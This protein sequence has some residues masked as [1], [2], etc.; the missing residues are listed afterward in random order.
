MEESSESRKEKLGTMIIQA[1]LASKDQIEE[2][3]Q[4]QK[5]FGGSLGTNLVEL[6]LL[7]D[8]ALAVFLSK[9]VGIARVEAAEW[10]VI[11]QDTLSKIPVRAA[12]QLSIIP[13]SE[14]EDA[15]VV[16]MAD[17]SDARIVERIEQNIGY[18]LSPK[19]APEFRIHI[20]LKQFYDVPLPP[21]LSRLLHHQSTNQKEDR[22]VFHNLL[23]KVA[24][25]GEAIESY[26]EHINDLQAIPVVNTV[27]DIKSLP[28]TPE[29]IFVFQQIDGVSTLEDMIQ[30]SVFS[31]LDTLRSLMYFFDNDLIEFQK[32]S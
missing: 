17:P 29:L 12:Q 8:E 24:P 20:A 7:D 25:S 15:L 27:K 14:T 32:V 11:S 5:V 16:A 13:L 22:A 3:L 2:A 9:Q 30:L 19:I 28:M 21:R 18:K 10:D 26:F 31:K 1:G 6:G 23:N 4:A